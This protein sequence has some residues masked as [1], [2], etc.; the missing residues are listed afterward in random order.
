MRNKITIFAF[1]LL[2]FYIFDNKIVNA[3]PT[4]NEPCVITGKILKIEKDHYSNKHLIDQA[5]NAGL[6]SRYPIKTIIEYDYYRV[7]LKIFSINEIDKANNLEFMG[8]C[9]K[10]DIKNIQE[11]GAI[12]SKGNQDIYSGQ[13]IKAQ[14][15]LSGDEFFG[16][17]YLSNIRRII[18]TPRDIILY[19]AI[20]FIVIIIFIFIKI[21]RRKTE[22]YKLF[23]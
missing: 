13:K 1:L 3:S 4:I 21:K 5:I 16:G 20:L 2:V 18:F 11:W 10:A 15:Q 6:R 14:I 17:Y 23:K 22:I 8:G 19:S 12:L 9:G 7:Y